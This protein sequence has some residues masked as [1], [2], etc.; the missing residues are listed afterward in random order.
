MRTILNFIKLDMESKNYKSNRAINQIPN[1]LCLFLAQKLQ[2]Y[3]QL[4]AQTGNAKRRNDE[5]KIYFTIKNT[6]FKEK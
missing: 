2:F 6:I 4:L 3:T 1:Q 5:G